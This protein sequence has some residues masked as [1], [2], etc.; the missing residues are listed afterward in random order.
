MKENVIRVA[1]HPPFAIQVYRIPEGPLG[2]KL[3]KQAWGDRE[4]E[5]VS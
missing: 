4:G 3:G 2:G 1:I 5:R